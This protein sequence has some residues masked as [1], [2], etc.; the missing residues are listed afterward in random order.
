MSA[1]P[2]PMRVVN[3][4]LVSLGRAANLVAAGYEEGVTYDMAPVEP[5]SRR[6][7]DHEFAALHEGWLNLPPHLAVQFP[8][9]E[10]LRK[11]LLIECGFADVQ[12]V[13]CA[14]RA[15]AVRWAAITQAREAYSVATVEGSVLRIFTA[16]S[17]SRKAMPGREFQASKT[18]I[19]DKLAEWLGVDAGSLTRA[20]A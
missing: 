8:T 3:G 5:R 10:H 18:A 2:I 16:R 11:R 19:L 12:D 1:Q 6:S 7:H 14:T 20:A 13:V 17:Q 4:H 9:E 15:E